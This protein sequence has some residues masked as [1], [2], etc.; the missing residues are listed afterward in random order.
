MICLRCGNCCIHLD[1]MIV[2][3]RSIR[4]DGTRDP[5]DPDS[6]I[7][8]P[9]GQR[10]PHLVCRDDVATCTIHELPCYRGTPCEQFEQFGREDD[11][12]IMGRYFEIEGK[13]QSQ[14]K[15]SI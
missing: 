5:D 3:P 9:S 8:K 1:V 13:L 15:F 7:I 10:C 12:C 6:M 11:V 4:P 14:K 2:N